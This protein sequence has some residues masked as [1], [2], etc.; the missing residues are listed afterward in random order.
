VPIGRIRPLSSAAAM[1]SAGPIDAPILPLQRSS[2][3]APTAAPVL[4]L[5][6][7]R[8]ALRCAEVQLPPGGPA[9][10]QGHAHVAERLG[11]GADQRLHQSLVV[12]AEQSPLT[13][14]GDGGLLARP[15][16][17]LIGR[18]GVLHGNARQVAGDVGQAEVTRGRLA[19][20]V[21][22]HREAPDPI[23][24][25]Y[26]HGAVSTSRPAGRTAAPLPGMPPTT[27]RWRYLR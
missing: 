26:L 8:P 23:T 2:T 13:E 25:P 27:D 1:S 19:R 16:A 10:E 21:V 17:Q 11:D 20:L 9:L 12:A 14:C 22:I 3:S 24:R 6:A 7:G 5:P 15:P 4:G 18:P